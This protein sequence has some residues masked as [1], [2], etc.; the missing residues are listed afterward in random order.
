MW[1]V[2][3]YVNPREKFTNPECHKKSTAATNSAG[4][5]R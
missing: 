3:D 2:R 4:H 5:Y 1:I